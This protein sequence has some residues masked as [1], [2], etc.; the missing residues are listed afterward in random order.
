MIDKD[1]KVKFAGAGAS[2]AGNFADKA[3][4]FYT[5]FAKQGDLNFSWLGDK[6][7]EFSE[8]VC[9]KPR[10]HDARIFF[11]QERYFSKVFQS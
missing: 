7:G 1:G 5:S 4:E 3:L 6:A 11:N 2:G 10:C 9:R 8:Y